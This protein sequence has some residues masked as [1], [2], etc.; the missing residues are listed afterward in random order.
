MANETKWK[1]LEERIG[2]KHGKE[3]ADAIKEL[4]AIFGTDIVDW[5][6][7]LYDPEHGAWYYS[8]SAQETEGYL[9]NAESTLGGVTFMSNYGATEGKSPEECIPKWLKARVA[10]FIYNLQDEDGYFY[11]PQWGKTIS[12]L[13]S[14]R[15]LGTCKWLLR[16]MDGP[17]PKYQTPGAPKKE[18]AGYDINNAPERFRTL[19]NYK[20]YLYN[21]LNFDTRGYN[22]GSEMSSQMG[23]VEAYGNILGV[24]L[25]KLTLDYIES[26]QRE[27]TGLWHPEKSYYASNG[28]QKITK[29]FNWYGRKIPYAMAGLESVMEIIMKDDPVGASVDVYNP[30]HAIGSLMLNLKKYHGLTEAEYEE[31]KERVYC[32]APDAIRKSTEKMKV[33]K[34]PDGG[35]S[36]LVK[37]S[38]PTD[39]GAKAAVPGSVEGDVNGCLCAMGIIPSIYSGLDLED[40]KV[41]LFD[42]EDFERYIGIITEREEA[43]KNGKFKQEKRPEPKS[44]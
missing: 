11:H 1:A 18:G 22:S 31:I 2:E 43:Y 27:D 41:S 21:Q 3:I 40:A 28:M 29:M 17:E 44:E 4:Y 13:K 23:E 10:D 37:T 38:C 20:D 42:P 36:Y 9:P 39:Q 19:D 32:W 15:D 35:M 7:G 24:D 5:I 33:F 8:K 26:K 16:M 25:I 12:H 30:W 6:A 14:S 34:K